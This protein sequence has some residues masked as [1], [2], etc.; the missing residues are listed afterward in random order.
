MSGAVVSL[1]AAK[2]VVPEHCGALEDKQAA[3]VDGREIIKVRSFLFRTGQQ[4]RTFWGH[5]AAPTSGNTV[6]PPAA[7]SLIY[8]T[9]RKAQRLQHGLEPAKAEAAARP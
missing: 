7:T 3:A 6:A 5:T 9:D 1:P 4:A 2:Q 8:N